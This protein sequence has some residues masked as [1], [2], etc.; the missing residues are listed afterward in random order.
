MKI[1]GGLLILNLLIPDPLPF[2]DEIVMLVGTILLTRWAKAAEAE[3]DTSR[4]PHEPKRVG[5]GSTQ[6]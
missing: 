1:G 4:K 6:P 3:T 2:V 5:R